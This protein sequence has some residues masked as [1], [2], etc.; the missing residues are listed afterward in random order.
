MKVAL[1][2]LSTLIWQAIL[3]ACLWHLRSEIRALLKRLVSVKY[4]DTEA[5]FQEQA[6]VPLEPSPLASQAMKV[7]DEDGFFTKAGIDGMVQQSRYFK[8]NDSVRDA[9]LV[10]S[11][12]RQH[13]WL[14]A[15]SSDVYFVL[16]DESTRANERLIQ[17]LVPLSE[18]LPVNA[19]RE[20]ADA[21]SFQLGD[22][23]YWYY[24]RN[25]LGPPKTAI[26]RLTAFIR[27]ALGQ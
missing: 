6:A 27:T 5:V 1:E 22:S 2:F 10:F 20:S 16:D 23:G 11:T 4:G 24:S 7:R 18:A 9:I 25:L 15:T 8:P 26:N 17:K 19:Q 12:T 21:G 14:V 13:T 3:V